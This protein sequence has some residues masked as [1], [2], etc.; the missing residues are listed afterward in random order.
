VFQSHLL[1]GFGQTER[2]VKSVMISF[3]FVK[4]KTITSDRRKDLEKMIWVNDGISPR[5][6]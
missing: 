2:L 1:N 3:V 5:R 6:E 4:S